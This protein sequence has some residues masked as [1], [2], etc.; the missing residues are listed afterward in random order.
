MIIRHGINAAVH[1]AGGA[2]LGLLAV[3][4]ARDLARAAKAHQAKTQGADI[5]AD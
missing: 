5:A 4:A 1:M 3:F 2:L